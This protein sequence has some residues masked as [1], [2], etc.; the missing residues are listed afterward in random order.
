MPVVM[1]RKT[2]ESFGKP[3][4]G[5]RNIIITRN[6][7][8]KGEGVETADSI[9]GAIN[10]AKKSDVKEIFIIGGGEVFKTIISEADRIYITRIH[11][12][13]DGDA[14]FPEINE[15]PIVPLMKRMLILIASR[16]GRE[17]NSPFYILHFTFESVFI[18]SIS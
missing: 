4:R 3:L 8:W 15:K 9:E 12:S 5:R 6:K 18:F 11:H 2:Y 1:G 7:D 13:F 14:F 17:N 10:L 16:F